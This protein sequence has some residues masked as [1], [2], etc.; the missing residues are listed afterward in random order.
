[1]IRPPPAGSSGG[2]SSISVHQLVRSVRRMVE[3]GRSSG[4]ATG[5]AHSTDRQWRQVP[6]INVLVRQRRTPPKH[7][8]LRG[9][10][11]LLLL[12]VAYAVQE[13]Y[14]EK[15]DVEAG[16]EDMTVR[17][18]GLQGQVAAVQRS[19]EPLQ[20]QRNQLK[21]QLEARELASQQIIGGQ[22]N[23][24]GAFETLFDIHGSGVILGA[25]EAQPGGRLLVVGVATESNS[26]A[27]L[28]E[29]LSFISDQLD[30]QGIRWTLESEPPEFSATFLVRK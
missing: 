20:A 23:W 26:M 28:P 25:V 1:M 14:R 2:L 27:T 9:L 22:I 10:L 16:V 30:F 18:Q 15:M 4:D 11:V 12:G 13:K 21:Q 19:V 24:H 8:L 7:L 17:L 6:K 3:G 29:R 5:L